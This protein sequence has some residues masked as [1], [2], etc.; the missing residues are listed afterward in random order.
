MTN[1]QLV[2]NWYAALVAAGCMVLMGYDASVFNSIQSSSNWKAHFG[3]PNPNMI[4]LINT[5]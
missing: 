3:H 5:T 1:I 4:G 2:Y